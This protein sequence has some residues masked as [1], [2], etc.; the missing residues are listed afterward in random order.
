[1]EYTVQKLA[2]MAGVSTRT[3]RYYDEIGLLKP[4][5][6]NSSGYR[7]YGTSE[8]NRLQQILFYRELGVNLNDISD[9]VTAPSFDGAKALREHHEKLLEKREQLNQLIANVEKTIAVTEGRTIMSDK[10]KFEGF[11]QTLIDENEKKYGKEI[12]EKYGK[13]TVEKSNRKIKNMTEEEYETVSKLA[14]EIN[15]KLKE[16]YKTGDPAGELSQEVADLHR[17]WLCFY[18]DSYSGEA[19]AG[20][21]QMYV[22]DERFTAYYDK[23]QPGTAKFL[24]DAIFIYTGTKN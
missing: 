1:M 23:E 10:E 14:E 2:N 12:R 20:I 17:K 18:W 22:D 9:I 16:A 8:V 21:A 4:A 3:L 6:I 11:K 24:R 15:L 5:R 19:H 7:I 13:E